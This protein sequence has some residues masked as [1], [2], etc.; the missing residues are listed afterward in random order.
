MSEP[1]EHIEIGRRI[2]ALRRAY[3]DDSQKVW[4]ARHGFSSTQYS[5]WEAGIR[6]IPVECAARLCDTYG[7]TLDFIYRGR[8]D[9]LSDTARKKV[10][11]L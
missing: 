9:G 11:S 2:A 1:A 3:S 7:L 6:R 4:A 10:S 5:N 8:I